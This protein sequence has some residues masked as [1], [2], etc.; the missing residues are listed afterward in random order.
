MRNV[1][2]ILIILVLF[3]SACTQPMD[4]VV[5]SVNKT[6]SIL[7]NNVWQLTDYQIVVENS[8]IPPPLLIPLND[9]LI[10]AGNYH[11]D[12]MSPDDIDFKEY[13]FLFL[14]DNTIL[15][16][17]GMNDNFIGLGGKYFVW[18]EDKCRINPEGVTRLDYRYYY[19]SDNKQMIFT[20]T[21]DDASKAIDKINDRLINAAV[22]EW[23]NHLGSAISDKI[24]NSPI[25]KHKIENWI[26]HAIAGN[27]PNIFFH[28]YA[29]N[30]EKL[31]EHVRIH[32]LDSINWKEVLKDALKSK[33]GE[34]NTLNPSELV[35]SMSEEIVAAIGTEFTTIE[36]VNIITPY[37]DG[38][39][40]QDPET[41]ADHIATLIVKVLGRVFSE[42]NLEK[43]IE[44]IWDKFTQMSDDQIDTVALKF[45]EIVQEH[46][47]NPDT[48]SKIFIPITT[49][50]DDTPITKMGK[51]AQDATDSLEV[52]VDKLNNR[53]PDLGLDPDYPSIEPKIKAIFVAAKPIISIKGPEEVAYEIA[54]LITNQ[55]L[56]TENIEGVFV[57]ALDY[58]QSIDP[59]VA[60]ETIAQWIVSIEERIAPE[61]ALWL[62]EK[63]S[64]ILDNQN[65]KL[66]SLAIGN[67]VR[68]FTNPYF[69]QGYIGE[70]VLRE[71]NQSYT[72]NKKAVAKHIAQLIIDKKLAKEGV[73]LEQLAELIRPELDGNGGSIG[74]R[75]R[76]AMGAQDIIRDGKSP[77]I[78]AKVITFIIYNMM[79]ENLKVADNFKEAT[80]II[81]HE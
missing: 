40:H 69:N 45:T 74:D 35:P 81:S 20:L 14:E 77:D 24:H 75:I 26:K 76:D 44:P 55:F 66:T 52:F 54:T 57:K 29:M 62:A 79:W 39:E 3:S 46:W 65:P 64:P 70:F 11:L 32:M 19:D 34:I 30:S 10:E 53:F 6:K 4:P 73:D 67:R 16:D 15:T 58:L 5:E 13:F 33:I 59:A 27:L 38:L 42:D 71:M 21:G 23:P 47:L 12:D 8:D 49:K 1:N 41:R 78:I 22:E 7:Q 25:I 72:I 43:I 80:I 36:L 60:A 17:T 68:E 2:Y 63:L 37:M 18:N 50:I 56:N 48:L 9:S 28:D 31:A 61:L 51:L